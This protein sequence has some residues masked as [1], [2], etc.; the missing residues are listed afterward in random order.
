MPLESLREESAQLSAA[1]YE[2]T[3]VPIEYSSP[4]FAVSDVACSMS[5]EHWDVAR[6]VLCD[7]FLPSGAVLH[8]AQFEALVRSIWLLH[9]ASDESIT[10]FAADLTISSEQ[11]A[12]NQPAVATMMAAIA[13]SAPP[14]AH[15]ALLRFKNNSW[16]ALNSYVHAGIHP[17]QRHAEGYPVLLIENIVRNCNGIGV[18]ACMQVVALR[19]RQ[20]MQRQVLDLAARYADCLPA[21]LEGRT[22][23]P[24]D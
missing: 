2:L 17:I 20:P 9:A 3:D 6:Q 16:H 15:D 19:G 12:K 22:G 23:A 21:P 8:R 24:A 10:K 18:M 4:R 14:Q 7:G 13:K 1:L 5:M 11:D